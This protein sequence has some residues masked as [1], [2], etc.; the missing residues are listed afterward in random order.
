ML[1]CLAL[2]FTAKAEWF[3]IDARGKVVAVS[4]LAKQ[5]KISV[6]I[7]STTWCAPCVGLK[8]RLKATEFDMSK[9]DFYYMVVADE[10]IGSTWE[11]TNFG[12]SWRDIEGLNGFPMIYITAQTTNIVSKFSAEEDNKYERVVKVVNSLLLD[13]KNFSDENLLDK[14]VGIKSLNTHSEKTNVRVQLFITKNLPQKLDMPKF[15]M[16]VVTLER[17]GNNFILYVDSIKDM[18]DAKSIV[19]DAKQMGFKDASIVVNK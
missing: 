3:E 5:G 16:G 9:V 15:D 6:F 10:T 8:K 12:S 7:V 13:G 19:T 17:V 14:V 2:S 1:L 18:N 11:Q 4:K